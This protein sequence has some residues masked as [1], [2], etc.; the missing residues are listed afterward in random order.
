METPTENTHIN[1]PT[2]PASL[3]AHHSGALKTWHVS[4]QAHWAALGRVDDDRVRS[5]FAVGRGG[6]KTADKTVKN[7][8]DRFKSVRAR[9]AMGGRADVSAYH[10]VATM[11]ATVDELC[12]AQGERG[13]FNIVTLKSFLVTLK[14]VAAHLL[15]ACDERVRPIV[16]NADDTLGAKLDEI[17]RAVREWEKQEGLRKFKRAFGDVDEPWDDVVVPMREKFVAKFDELID[18]LPSD[19]CNER[20]VFCQRAMIMACMTMQTNELHEES[21]QPTRLNWACTVVHDVTKI[22]AYDGRPAS[23][24]VVDAH[25]VPQK[26]IAY[27]KCASELRWDSRHE[28]PIS[29]KLQAMLTKWLHNVSSIKENAPLSL[30]LTTKSPAP[31][32]AAWLGKEITTACACAG[33]PKV[34]NTQLRKAYETLHNKDS[35]KR[36]RRMDYARHGQRT[37]DD[38]YTMA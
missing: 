12:A 23:Y 8:V 17:A 10:F 14:K 5:I 36:M 13:E 9:A 38:R 19:P 16:K 1:T 22:P 27:D 31:A 4:M 24:L 2:S 32:T 15:T 18:G 6:G 11:P 29:G 30:F 33:H 3:M 21:E 35:A 28:R 25:G 20:W 34:T 37:A 26:L 7:N